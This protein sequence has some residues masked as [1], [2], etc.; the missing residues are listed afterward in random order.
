MLA[1]ALAGLRV[2]PHGVDLSVFQPADRRAV[3]ARLGLPPDVPVLLLTAGSH[4]SV[5]KD[6]RTMHAAMSA[7]ADRMAGTKVIFMALEDP[8]VPMPGG[9]VEVR[10]VG[11]QTDPAA[12]ARFYQAADVYLHAARADTFPTAVLEALA[13][14]TPV[15]ASDVGG[16]SEQV[17]PM[18]LDGRRAGGGAGDA[19][20]VLVAPRDAAAL[21]EAA[22][23]LIQDDALRRAL[24][25]NAARDARRR[26]DHARQVD[27]YLSWYREVVADWRG[28]PVPHVP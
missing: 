22:V 13:C 15:V 24:G 23:A 6:R 14:G 7:I 20:G 5:W 3:R 16:I 19:T 18:G 4:H 12:L 11:Y 1:P 27:D 8:G 9:R 28:R 2:I 17:L 10:C 21:A 26:F 25:D